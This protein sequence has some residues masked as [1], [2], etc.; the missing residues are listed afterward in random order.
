MG[1]KHHVGRTAWVFA[2]VVVVSLCGSFVCVCVFCSE[3]WVWVN[4]DRRP[5]ADPHALALRLGTEQ[6]TPGHSDQGR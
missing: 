6:G 4:K 2:L 3:T 1:K 5:G